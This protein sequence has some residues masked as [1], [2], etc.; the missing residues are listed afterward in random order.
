MQGLTSIVCQDLFL[1]EPDLYDILLFDNDGDQIG[2]AVDTEFQDTKVLASRTYW[3]KIKAHRT[4]DL[5]T[6]KVVFNVDTQGDTIENVETKFD[7]EFFVG[8]FTVQP[9]DGFKYIDG[10]AKII[11]RIESK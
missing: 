9:H 8:K 3:T 10:D 6:E 11:P 5:E 1:N 4:V 7:G 2:E